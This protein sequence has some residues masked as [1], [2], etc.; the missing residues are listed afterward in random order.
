MPSPASSR[1]ASVAVALGSMLDMSM[2]SWPA[3][4][5]AAMPSAP[6]STASTISAVLRLVMMTSLALVRRRDAFHGDR[7]ARDQR[8]QLLRIHVSQCTVWRAKEARRDSATHDADADD[9]DGLAQL[10]F[11]P[12][13][14]RLRAGAV[15]SRSISRKPTSIARAPLPRRCRHE[16]AAS[17]VRP[18]PCRWPARRCPCAQQSARTGGRS[19]NRRSRAEGKVVGH[20]DAAPLALH[21]ARPRRKYRRRKQRLHIRRPLQHGGERLAAV[22]EGRPAHHRNAAPVRSDRPASRRAAAKPFM[23]SSP[24]KSAPSPSLPGPRRRCDDGRGR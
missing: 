13:L 6:K 4:A 20:A 9:A 5:A 15:V 18:L 19:R 22:I 1:A 12:S 10:D 23:R 14:R 17:A 7:P 3:F 24:R 2:K 8:R 21:H 11:L 16:G